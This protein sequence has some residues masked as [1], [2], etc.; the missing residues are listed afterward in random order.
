MLPRGVVLLLWVSSSWLMMLGVLLA[1]GAGAPRPLTWLQLRRSKV[2]R[3]L[4]PAIHYYYHFIMMKL[5]NVSC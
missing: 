3:L 4:T 2:P 1:G 5:H